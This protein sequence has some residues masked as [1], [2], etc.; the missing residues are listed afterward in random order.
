MKKTFENFDNP[1]APWNINRNTKPFKT[2]DI[3][4]TRNFIGV[5]YLSLMLTDDTVSDFTDCYVRNGLQG[6]E[7]ITKDSTVVYYYHHCVKGYT[8]KRKNSEPTP[9]VK[10]L[11][12]QVDRASQSPT[13]P[14]GQW[15]DTF[16]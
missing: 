3:Y 5:D 16:F 6:I 10:N 15:E 1:K 13:N 2:T 12:N 8:Y 9:I 4:D 14:N 7:I 11:T